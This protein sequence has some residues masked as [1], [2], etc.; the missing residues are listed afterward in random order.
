MASA[1]RMAACSSGWKRERSPIMRRLMSLSL[2]R[3]A[4]RRSAPRNSSINALTSSAGRCQFS[5]EKANRVNTSTPASAHTS[6]TARTASTPAL[7][8]A[9]PGSRRFL[10]QRLLPSMMIATCRGT[11]TWLPSLVLSMTIPWPLNGHQIRFFLL[12]SHFDLGHEL[13][14]QLLDLV[15]GATLFVFADF[16][17]LDQVFQLAQGIATNIAHGDTT[18]LGGIT[19]LLGEALAGFLGQ[20]RHGDQQQLAQVG[21]IEAQ[22]GALDRLVDGRQHIALEGHD[23][24]GARILDGDVGHLIQR[25]IRT[26]V[27]HHHATE[28]ARVR[29]TGTDTT[30]CMEQRLQ[31]LLHAHLGVLLDRVD[32]SLFSSIRVPS[33]PPTTTF[34]SAPGLFILKTRSGILWSR[35][36]QIAVRSMTPSLRSSTSS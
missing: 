12:N 13:V 36:R 32:H 5:L 21:R 16:L 4:S 29:L 23:L 22:T 26:V 10:A 24:Q 3:L 6:I 19:G 20:G 35:H 33:A 27:R 25:G 28:D 9:T 15:G 8:P 1:S 18:I 2:R 17:F 31:A 34:S 14:G 30:E 7:W 11:A